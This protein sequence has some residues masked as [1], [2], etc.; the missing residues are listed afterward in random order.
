MKYFLI[1][2]GL[3]GL[4]LVYSF[5]PPA[6]FMDAMNIAASGRDFYLREPV[7]YLGLLGFGALLVLGIV[8]A[9]RT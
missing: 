8:K 7:Y 3:V 4:I 1:G 5:R 9:I 6:G 2:I